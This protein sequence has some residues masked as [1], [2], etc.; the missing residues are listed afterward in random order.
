MVG[1]VGE[2]HQLDRTGSAGGIVGDRPGPSGIGVDVLDDP[3]VLGEHA[4]PTVRRRGRGLTTGGGDDDGVD[5]TVG[6]DDRVQRVGRRRR[7]RAPN[8]T[9]WHRMDRASSAAVE[10]RGQTRAVG[11]DDT[12]PHLCR[13]DLGRGRLVEDRTE[14]GIAAAGA[15]LLGLGFGQG[16]GKDHVEHPGEGDHMVGAHHFDEAGFV[17]DGHFRTAGEEH[18]AGAPPESFTDQVGAERTEVLGAGHREEGD[19][20]TT[21]LAGLPGPLEGRGHHPGGRDGR[22]GVDGDARWCLPSQLP[23]E[24]GDGPLGAAVGTGI[25][26]PPP[27]AGGDAEDAAVPGG[28]HERQCGVEHVEVALEVHGQHRQPVLL[29]AL[30]EVGLPGDAGDIDDGVEPAVL[31][32][33]LPEQGADRLGRRSPTPMRPGPNHPPPRCDRPWSPRAPEAAR[34]RRGSPAGRR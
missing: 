23:G 32:D 17:D 27:R 21:R 30:S 6:F 19:A 5:R 20:A 10:R 22:H 12:G 15:R 24:G 29:G 11:D 4:L 8:S 9:W 13:C 18:P 26:G 2:R 34:T 14:P 7:S 1:G 3:A 25:G 31:V 33:Q 28:G 16:T